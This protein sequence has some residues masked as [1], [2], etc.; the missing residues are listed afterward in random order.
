MALQIPVSSFCWL[1]ARTGVLII[2]WQELTMLLF[3]CALTGMQRGFFLCFFKTFWPISYTILHIA[4]SYFLKTFLTHFLYWYAVHISIDLLNGTVLNYFQCAVD[5]I[6]HSYLIYLKSSLCFVMAWHP[7]YR[8]IMPWLS[9]IHYH[10]LSLQTHLN[11]IPRLISFHA[12]FKWIQKLLCLSICFN[13]THM[14]IIYLL[15][16][17]GLICFNITHMSNI[18]LLFVICIYFLMKYCL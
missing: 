16:A 13:I 17:N 11:H 2:K 14:C 15:Y 4:W 8:L 9:Y 6:R 3:G 5:T 1:V 10:V 18:Y 12:S 7:A